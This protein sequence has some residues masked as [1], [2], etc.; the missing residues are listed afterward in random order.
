VAAKEPSSSCAVAR[1]IG[2]WLALVIALT[3]VGA[4]AQGS[5]AVVVAAVGDDDAAVRRVADIASVRLRAHGAAVVDVERAT[6]AV[7]ASLGRQAEPLPEDLARRLATAADAILEHVA[8]GRTEQASDEA[9]PLFDLAD[10]HLAAIGTDDAARAHLG[11]ICL[12]LVRALLHDEREPEARMRALECVRFPSVEPDPQL[13]PANVR[14]FFGAMRADVTSEP[15]G[16]LAIGADPGC[17]VRVN[18]VALGETPFERP[19]PPGRYDVQVACGSD[20][21]PRVRRVDVPRGGR[22]ALHFDPGLAVRLV[23]RDGLL[24]RYEDHAARDARLRADA[25]SLGRLLDVTNVL[26]VSVR[27]E[28][29]SLLR[30]SV[31]EH[32]ARVVASAEL[33]ADPAPTADRVGAAVTAL[34]EAGGPVPGPSGSEADGPSALG[35]VLGGVGLLGL[36]TSWI[37][38][39]TWLGEQRQVDALDPVANAGDLASAIDARDDRGALVVA[40]GGASAAVLTVAVPMLLPTSDGVP[41]WSWLAGAVGLAATTLGIVHTAR[42][43]QDVDRDLAS[44]GTE[45][46]LPIRTIPL[47][48][49]VAMHGAPLIAMPITHLIRGATES[50]TNAAAAVSRDGARVTVAVPF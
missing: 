15:H 22:A 9:A 1:G 40:I 49:L 50:E 19:V 10:E 11:N 34:L 30:V 25:R 48:P 37:L 2:A 5:W 44:D 13:H 17:T 6:R 33:P 12:F 28:V 23:A 18:G 8:F 43:S 47:G 32:E 29:L 31:D 26:V 39:G 46:N 36:V 4:R 45:R 27:D 16:T 7:E 38:Y 3:S 41:W 35:L 42:D 14:D 21:A 24:L 20:G